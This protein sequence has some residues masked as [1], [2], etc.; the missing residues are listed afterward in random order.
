MI[1]YWSA[2]ARSGDPNGAGTPRWDRF[3]PATG[4]VQS[5]APALDSPRRPSEAGTALDSPR[6]PKDQAS[7]AG[8]ALDSPRRPSEAGTALE[9]IGPVDLGAEHRWGFWSTID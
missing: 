4:A 2:F 1:G 7:E 8:T 9:R 3:Q 5:L 6:R